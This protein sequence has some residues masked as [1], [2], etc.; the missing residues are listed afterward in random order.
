MLPC[1]AF[2]G[3]R[4]AKDGHPGCDLRSSDSH[5]EEPVEECAVALEGLA[6]VFGVYALTAGPLF[7]KLLALGCELLGDSLDD[8]GHE[9][10][11]LLDGLARLIDEGGL[12]LVPARAEVVEFVVGK[13]G[14][15][16]YWPAGGGLH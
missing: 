16:L 9:A 5:C 8:V 1:A 11:R 12:N 15:R 6:E 14:T 2:P 7:F 10:V 3:Q 4:L 13:E